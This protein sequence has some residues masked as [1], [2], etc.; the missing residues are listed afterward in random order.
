MTEVEERMVWRQFQG[1]SLDIW[2]DVD[3]NEVS[4]HL[5]W[6]TAKLSWKLWHLVSKIPFISTTD[7]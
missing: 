2:K 4:Y 3:T 6:G 7:C 5:A 1:S